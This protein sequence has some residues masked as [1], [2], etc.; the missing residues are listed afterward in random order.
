MSP[1]DIDR[2]KAAIASAPGRVYNIPFL[3]PIKRVEIHESR[4]V[5]IIAR[6]SGATRLEIGNLSIDDFRIITS[7]P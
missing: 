6:R 5:A 1:T 3:Y 2:L 7:I 4:P